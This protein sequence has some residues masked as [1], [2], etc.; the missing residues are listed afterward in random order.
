MANHVLLNNV[1][2]KNLKVV[3]SYTNT[4]GHDQM[5]VPVFPVEAR[6][7][8]AHYPLIFAKDANGQFQMV[9]LLGL[10][11]GENVFLNEG[12]WTASYKPLVVEK[13]PFLIGRNVP[14][15]SGEET[16]SIHVD[17]DDERVLMNENPVENAIDVF[18]PH[19]GNSEYIDNIANVLSTLHQSHERHKN[20]VDTLVHYS[21]IESFVVDVDVD[22]N[23]THR[24]SG[25]YTINED[26][27]KGLNKDALG[28]LHSN[29]DLDTI[30]MMLASMSQLRRIVALKKASL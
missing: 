19:G 30:Y 7:A 10:E 22:G 8:Q 29:G 23:G 3:N 16:L 13:G 4:F 14:G 21:L 25:F 11:Q 18:L 6:H 17:L 24:L 2:H 20:F 15:E 27:L 9:A 28:S 12:Q 1:E 5:C 26:V